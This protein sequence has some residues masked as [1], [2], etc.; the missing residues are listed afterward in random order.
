[1]RG[2]FRLEVLHCTQAR[3]ST[4]MHAIEYFNGCA[5]PLCLQVGEL[6][7]DMS[8]VL[9]AGNSWEAGVASRALP[10]PTSTDSM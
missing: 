2:K 4:W 9:Y 3:I 8:R 10:I 5:A 1:M 7:A 6:H